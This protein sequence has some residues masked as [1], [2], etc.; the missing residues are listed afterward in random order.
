MTS[1][2]QINL[3]FTEWHTLEWLI[4]AARWEHVRACYRPP[5]QPLEFYRRAQQMSFWSLPFLIFLFLFLWWC[6]STSPA[7]VL[8]S[9]ALTSAL[10]LGVVN[11]PGVQY[12]LQQSHSPSSPRRALGLCAVHFHHLQFISLHTHTLYT[13]RTWGDSG[14][15][16]R[17]VV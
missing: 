10:C 2:R 16:G 8:G 7:F 13:N 15:G 4:S 1:T 12:I 11:L 17:E 3:S 5:V 14:T 9:S 6:S